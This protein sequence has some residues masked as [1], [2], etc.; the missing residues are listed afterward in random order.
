VS[1]VFV[2]SSDIIP[3]STS[4]FVRDWCGRAIWDYIYSVIIS[5]K[6]VMVCIHLF[7][8][9]YFIYLFIII[10]I[11]LLFKKIIKFRTSLHKN[12][13]AKLLRCMFDS[14]AQ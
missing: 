3:S 13:R 5:L 8:L 11:I 9:F 1:I 2:S 12:C 4:F 6:V 10:I 14:E 7:I